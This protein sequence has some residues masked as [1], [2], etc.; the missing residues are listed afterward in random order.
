MLPLFKFEQIID[1]YGN[2]DRK[3]VFTGWWIDSQSSTMVFTFDIYYKDPSV[4][5]WPI[6][7]INS[8]TSAKIN[9]F[10]GKYNFYANS[11]LTLSINQNTPVDINTGWVLPD[12][13]VEVSGS[14][15]P[16]K[17]SR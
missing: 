13:D 2:I 12:Q 15:E 8:H 11:P 17:T 10:T 5:V 16:F 14:L 9:P 3:V 6:E 4:A 1:Q 7:L